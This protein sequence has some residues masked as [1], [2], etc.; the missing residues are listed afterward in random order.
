MTDHELHVAIVD[1]EESV[2]LAFA[3]ALRASFYAVSLH[4]SGEEFLYT[5]LDVHLPGISG[6][7]VQ[8]ALQVERPE[9]PIIIVTA[10]DEPATRNKCLAEG[11]VAYL[12]KPLRKDALTAAV[13][14]ALGRGASHQPAI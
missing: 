6:R 9:L 5:L 12:T 14:A 4:A 7:E 8:R 11:A 13:G 1:D 2:R 3:R 10:H